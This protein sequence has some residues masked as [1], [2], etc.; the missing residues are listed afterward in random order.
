MARFL[1]W[2]DLHTEFEPFSPPPM[3]GIDAVLVGGDT[4]VGTQHLDMLEVFWETYKVPVLSIRGNHEY[5]RQIWEEYEAQEAA[6]LT[7]FH[8][9][10]IPIHVLDGDMMVINGVRIIGATLWTDMRVMGDDGIFAIPKV[11]AALSDY[12]Q[13]RTRGRNGLRHIKATDTITKHI[14]DREKIFA[15]LETPF[16]G[17][18]LVMTH[19]MPTPACVHP[20]YKTDPITAAFASDLT[21]R[22]TQY[23][24]D[25]WTYGH[26]H[27][28]SDTTIPRDDGG[29]I[30]LVSNIRGYPHERVKTFDPT[31]VL[32]L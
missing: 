3:T 31:F 14:S 21:Y 24:I 13:I 6:R 9:Q 1:Y 11:E 30:A 28:Q 29:E 25:V 27:Q 15:H 19:H 17:K 10:N 7:A 23:P 4:G 26:T 8:D 2:S 20:M 18:T 12:H 5:Y 22:M 32:E 16:S